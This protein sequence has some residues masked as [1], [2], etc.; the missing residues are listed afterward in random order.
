MSKHRL[1]RDKLVESLFYLFS[2]EYDNNQSESIMDIRLTMEAVAD[3]L[4][5]LY[6]VSYSDNTWIYKQ[7]RN[8]EEEI[9]TRLFS[10][11]KDRDG[12]SCLQVNPEIKSFTQKRH[13]Y[14]SQKIKVS[15]GIYDLVVHSRKPGRQG[16]S[17]KLFL[18][19][20]STLYHLANI[21]SEKAVLD[22][23]QYEIHTNN[24]SVLNSFL[25]RG[26]D[27]P[28][29]QISSSGGV[30]D[31]VTNTF[32]GLPGE[33]LLSVP[34]DFVIQGAS[35]LVNGSLYVEDP[36]ETKQKKA[37]LKD[38]RGEKVLV[39]T[40]HEVFR[41]LP[42]EDAVPFGHLSDFSLLV[43]PH[44]HKGL[45]KNLDKMLLEEESLFSPQIINWNYRIYRINSP[46]R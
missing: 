9:R 39:L 11:I 31:P 6:D 18:G 14:I 44:N 19:A 2:Q 20:G 45:I 24:I 12:Q 26:P 34:F 28:N 41:Q 23:I 5:D 3:Y 10:L 1:K 17:V 22:G 46:S 42:L 15:N 21:I 16:A 37:L 36:D 8:Y 43:V 29:I 4:K 25:S 7:I 33:S 32:I 30:L 13:L 27:L 38:T 35:F 40:G